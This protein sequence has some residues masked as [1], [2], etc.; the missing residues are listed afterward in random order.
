MGHLACDLQR[1]SRDVPT[2]SARSIICGTENLA[3]TRC[4]I[5]TPVCQHCTS[6]S[7]V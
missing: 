3:S 1:D 6:A 5:R 7:K 4:D 2:S